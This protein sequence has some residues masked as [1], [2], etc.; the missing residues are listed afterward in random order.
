MLMTLKT[1]TFITKSAV[2]NFCRYGI[3]CKIRRALLIEQDLSPI[4]HLFQ[5]LTHDIHILQDN[6]CQFLEISFACSL[7]ERRPSMIGAWRTCCR[8][9]SRDSRHDA[10]FCER[11]PSILRRDNF[12]CNKQTSSYHSSSTISVSKRTVNSALRDVRLRLRPVF[13]TT[14]LDLVIEAHGQ[15]RFVGSELAE[16][17]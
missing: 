13:V 11:C 17:S 12:Y 2:S 16:S 8:N 10:L 1:L 4:L 15:L 5:K 7:I 9:P 6:T 3:T 14:R